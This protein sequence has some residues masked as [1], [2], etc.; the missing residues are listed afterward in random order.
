MAE[1]IRFFNKNIFKAYASIW[2]RYAG[3]N[4]F[5]L[6]LTYLKPNDIPDNCSEGYICIIITDCATVIIGKTY[7]TKQKSHFEKWLLLLIFFHFLF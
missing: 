6:V 5:S 4:V 7:S 2:N 1:C 3:C